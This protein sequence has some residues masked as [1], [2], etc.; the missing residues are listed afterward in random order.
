MLATPG[1]LPQGPDWVYE[2]RWDGLR[3]LADVSEGRVRLTGVEGREL[4]GV[5]PELDELRGLTPDVLLDGEV[6]VLANGVPSPRALAE[7]LRG[8]PQW[9]V[10]YLV[11]D[12]LRLYGVPLLERPLGERRGTL[13]RLNFARLR[14]VQISPLYTDG[15][16]LLAAVAEQGM[17]GVIAKRRYAPY[18][19]GVRS[20]DWIVVS[21]P[22]PRRPWR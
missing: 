6:V 21:P 9:P 18:Q 13:E 11:S 12:V 8:N 16:A 3:L 4:T 14:R 10:A 7:R 17:A 1:R 19:P 22:A 15:S 20:P 5:L 2:V